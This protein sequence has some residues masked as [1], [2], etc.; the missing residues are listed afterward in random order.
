M[1]V[2]NRR[3]VRAAWPMA[4]VAHFLDKVF[5]TCAAIWLNLSMWLTRALWNIST[6][7]HAT[8]IVC[9]YS[10]ICENVKKS[11]DILDPIGAQHDFV[12]LKTDCRLDKQQQEATLNSLLHKIKARFYEKMTKIIEP[13]TKLT[14]EMQSASL[15]HNPERK[16]L[17]RERGDCRG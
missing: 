7:P 16:L 8:S 17:S 11:I 15:S 14:S 12:N 1:G 9:N 5:G 6:W 3:D 2:N 4:V 13:V 10:C